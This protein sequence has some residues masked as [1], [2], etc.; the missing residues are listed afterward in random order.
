MEEEMELVRERDGKAD[1][2]DRITK[3]LYILDQ[4]FNKITRRAKRAEAL[5]LGR[6]T[7]R[8]KSKC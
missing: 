3:D 1:Q 6:G 8:K 2:Y 7:W 4:K 5:D